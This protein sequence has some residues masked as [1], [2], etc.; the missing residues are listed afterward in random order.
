V[1]VRRSPG[2]TSVPVV[3]SLVFV[4]LLAVACARFV[5][6]IPTVFFGDDLDNLLAFQR[7]EFAS[8][9]TQALAGVYV[10]KFR[11]V[12]AVAMHLQFA[13]F[14]HWIA[15]YMAV[16][17][18][19]HALSGALVFFAA[20]FLSGGSRVIAALLALAFIVSRLALYQVT[21]VTGLL[22]GLGTALFLTILLCLTRARGTSAWRLSLFS[23]LAA[24]LAVH[25]HERYIVVLP[26]LALAFLVLPGPAALN[27]GRKAL[28]VC[29][30]VA[31]AA[32]NVLFKLAVSGGHFFVGTGGTRMDFSLQRVA[33]HFAQAV[34]SVFGFNYG[35]DYLAGASWS[36]LPYGSGWLL[37]GAITLAAA[38]LLVAAWLPRKSRAGGPLPVAVPD[39]A[40]GLL[41]VL[42]AGAVLVPPALTIRMEQRWELQPFVLLLLLLAWAAGR[43]RA[44]MS[45]RRAA[46]LVG[47]A[48]LASVGQDM[49]MSDYFDRIF[50]R[51]SA[52][53]A[54]MALRDIAEREPGAV[55]PVALLLSEEHCYWTLREG[56]FFTVYSGKARPVRCLAGLSDAKPTPDTRLYADA[57]DHLLDVTSDWRA[58]AEEGVLAFDFLRAFDLGVINDNRPVD[59]PSS[60]GAVRMQWNSVVGAR[61][62]LVL[63]SGFTYR[64]DNV[65]AHSGDELRFG[66][67]MLFPAPQAAR[68]SVTVLDGQG[69]QLKHYSEEL[70]PP[71]VGGR[72]KFKPVA[73][74]LDDVEGDRVSVVFSAMPSG[75]DS[76]AQWIGYTQPRL[77]RVTPAYDAKPK[78]ALRESMKST[79]ASR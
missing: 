5:P 16:N 27:W 6:W 20:R 11:P 67:A 8:T 25:T 42:L 3:A 35:P 73:L 12:F 19:V 22:E 32:F 58:A 18:A 4:A 56:A 47:I 14:G 63:L 44:Y 61:E 23:V 57:G 71:S 7:G 66:L 30:C 9:W 60:R 29:L 75:D 17:L 48:A 74:A 46:V 33:D 38:V 36:E 34:L 79:D 59:T 50:L 37:G 62:T 55:T 54:T 43:A 77:V 70:V 13:S 45:R 53:V 64:F 52:R 49:L 68:A 26:W 51:S 65:P 15:G 2:L 1:E 78:T 39:A 28:L 40:W 69:K 10:E 31:A 76:T 21:Q 72:T 24:A 41:L